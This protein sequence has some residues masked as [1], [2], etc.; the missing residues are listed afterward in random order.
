M[1]TA[2]NY[3]CI[4]VKINSGALFWFNLKSGVVPNCTIKMTK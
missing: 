2:G 4:G 1:E 3:K